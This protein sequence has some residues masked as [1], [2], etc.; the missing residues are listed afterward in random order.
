MD[1]HEIKTIIEMPELDLSDIR[2]YWEKAIDGD[3]IAYNSLKYSY[4]KKLHRIKP[5][6]NN[7]DDEI[8][9]NVLEISVTKALERGIK[10]Q[11]SNF[12]SY[13]D[14]A[15]NSYFKNQL[16]PETDSLQLPIQLV[17][18]FTK[19]EDVYDNI[20]SLKEMTD[21]YQIE[22]LAK[23]FEYPLFETRLLYYSY[24]KWKGQSL[25][26]VDIDLTVNLLPGP[27]RIE[28]EIFYEKPIDNIKQTILNEIKES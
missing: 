27:Q 17:R 2:L 9:Y 26:Q 6:Y 23:G 12:E 10:F 1:L 14:M 11:I 4:M 28:W 3:N 24:I 15:S 5:L 19:L 20:P 16:L 22:L 7:L 25:R 13:M 18:A 8:F 21:Q